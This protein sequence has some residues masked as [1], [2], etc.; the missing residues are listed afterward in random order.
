M[1]KNS[2]GTGNAQNIAGHFLGF[3]MDEEVRQRKQLQLLKADQERLYKEITAQE[4][5][6][7]GLMRHHDE[8]VQYIAA[9]EK[10]IQEKYGSSG[11][12]RKKH[13]RTKRHSKSRRSKSRRSK[14]RRSKH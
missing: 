4:A 14:S 12:R 3:N 8:V 1:S 11:G 10:E 13:R 6:D 9:L 2:L 7:E 5:Q